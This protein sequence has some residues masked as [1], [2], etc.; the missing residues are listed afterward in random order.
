M[1]HWGIQSFSAKEQWTS[2]FCGAVTFLALLQLRS[3]AGQFDSRTNPRWPE[4]A[5]MS[6]SLAWT[7]IICGYDN[8]PCEC[9]ERSEPNQKW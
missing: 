7:I 6:L 2:N 1:N 3:T 4:H 8:M 9:C 5:G